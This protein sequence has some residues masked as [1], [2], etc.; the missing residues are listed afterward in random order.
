MQESGSDCTLEALTSNH[1]T[2]GLAEGDLFAASRRPGM[3]RPVQQA[4]VL[5]FLTQHV[6]FA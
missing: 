2:S 1:L 4:A 3:A 5:R 6:T